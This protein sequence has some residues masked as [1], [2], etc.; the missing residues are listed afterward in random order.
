MANFGFES[1]SP[2]FFL[3]SIY[4]SKV[5]RE[6][7][8][9]VQNRILQSGL[10]LDEN[11]HKGVAG[12]L[13]RHRDRTKAE[14][15]RSG[16]VLSQD[17]KSGRNSPRKRK[18]YKAAT[19]KSRGPSVK[20]HNQPEQSIFHKRREQR[21]KV[22]YFSLLSQ[23]P[24]GD[25]YL[26]N[27]TEKHVD[28]VHGVRLLGQSADWEQIWKGKWMLS[29]PKAHVTI[30]QYIYKRKKRTHRKRKKKKLIEQNTTIESKLKKNVEGT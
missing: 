25:T 15:C 3:L 11:K 1:Q 17:P 20:G 18:A 5:Q 9:P 6:H 30:L 8:C 2:V 4:I 7:R 10:I 13:G 14:S 22:P 16:G 28:I 27:P 19:L 24:A 23:L 12:V 26:P 29:G 21:N